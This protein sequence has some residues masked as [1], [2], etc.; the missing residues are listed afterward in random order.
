M[1]GEG[2]EARLQLTPGLFGEQAAVLAQNDLLAE[3][4]EQAQDERSEQQVARDAALCEQDCDH[5]PV[6][7]RQTGVGQ[8]E[9]PALETR[10]PGCG[11]RARRMQ[12][13]VAGQS[14]QERRAHVTDIGPAL[15]VERPRQCQP[16]VAD[17]GDE[18]EQEPA[19]E[20]HERPGIDA[21]R[22]A[23]RQGGHAEQEDQV[24]D[25]ITK[26]E[27]GTK[28]VRGQRLE[29]RPQDRLP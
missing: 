9:E 4:D 12:L 14:D 5:R 19:D 6:A 25:R 10:S 8:N 7:C 13:Q 15:D 3:E 11:P 17:V 1:R 23:Q 20:R 26:R 24:A 22:P 18:H 27:R 29:S 2:F 21:H 16:A 28:W